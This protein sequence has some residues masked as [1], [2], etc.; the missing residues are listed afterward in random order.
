MTMPSIENTQQQSKC[1][2][3]NVTH[4]CGIVLLP[5]KNQDNLIIIF[6]HLAN[7]VCTSLV[8]TVNTRITLKLSSNNT[9]VQIISGL[10]LAILIISSDKVQQCQMGSQ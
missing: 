9:P 4:S 10:P 1:W 2:Q 3:C 8:E 6:S 5:S 7:F